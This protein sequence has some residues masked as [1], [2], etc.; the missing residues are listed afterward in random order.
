MS[1]KHLRAHRSCLIP[2]RLLRL[3]AEQEHQ[4]RMCECAP[5]FQFRE[6]VARGE[7]RLQI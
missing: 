7:R 6:H 3:P 1:D 2:H 5:G 4:Q